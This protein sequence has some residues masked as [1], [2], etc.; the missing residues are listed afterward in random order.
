MPVPPGAPSMPLPAVTQPC[1]SEESARTEWP[2]RTAY[3]QHPEPKATAVQVPAA[4]QSM[5]G[6]A[7]EAV[8]VI[9]PETR[10]A[11]TAYKILCDTE[12]YDADRKKLTC[13]SSRSKVFLERAAAKKHLT[14]HKSDIRNRMTVV[15]ET[16]ILPDMRSHKLE[17]GLSVMVDANVY[18]DRGGDVWDG[19]LLA[20]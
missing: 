12:M 8:Q 17:G 11:S 10:I 9:D 5:L 13:C 19:G 18:P 15:P 4:A 20:T 2:S 1:A 7:N 16:K 3:P 6:S 14:Q